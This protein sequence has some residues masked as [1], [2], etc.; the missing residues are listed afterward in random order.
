MA[1]F[2]TEGVMPVMPYGYGNDGMFGGNGG[3]GMFIL[4]FGRRAGPS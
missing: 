2:T 3:W 4:G 1:G